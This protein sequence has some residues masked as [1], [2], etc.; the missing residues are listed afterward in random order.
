MF[1]VILPRILANQICAIQEGGIVMSGRVYGS[2]S[3]SSNST[4]IPFRRKLPTVQ[5]CDCNRLVLY[6][7][8]KQK[9]I[10]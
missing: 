7:N 10:E 5:Q 6:N 4:C 3:S 1:E 8:E 9:Q 2:S